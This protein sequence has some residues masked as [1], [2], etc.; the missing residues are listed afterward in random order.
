MR[1]LG[2]PVHILD[3]E[4]VLQAVE[5]WL[6]RR[7]GKHWIAVT[8]SHGLVEGRKNPAFKTILESADL[9]LPDGKWTARVAAKKI[10]CAPRQVRGA[11]FLQAFCRLSGQKGYSNFFY[12]DTEEVL[13]LC[14][15]RLPRIPP[16]AHRGRLF[17]AFSR[18][19]SARRR[20]NRQD[21]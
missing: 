12:G 8:S 1:V 3:L 17:P 4:Q 14:A 9:S 11:D 20:A 15:A 19:H 7:D 18:A 13:A 5:E 16:P 21:D 6:C 2:V 10:A